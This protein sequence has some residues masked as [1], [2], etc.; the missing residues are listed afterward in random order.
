MKKKLNLNELKVSS[1]VTSMNFEKEMTI[2]GG[3]DVPHL[4]NMCITNF[5]C[6]GGGTG[7]GGASRGCSNN[8][9]FEC[10]TE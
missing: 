1:F 6:P 5:G 10:Y 7:G 3:V 8:S 2:N 9:C 4:T